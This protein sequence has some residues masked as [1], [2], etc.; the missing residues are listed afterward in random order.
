[1]H[2]AKLC[3]AV[4]AGFYLVISSSEVVTT[5]G[6]SLIQMYL[7]IKSA[8]FFTS[9]FLQIKSIYRFTPIIAAW[10]TC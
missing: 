9:L 3:S 7:V 8:E 6:I 4:A 10:W 2:T 1:M 5:G